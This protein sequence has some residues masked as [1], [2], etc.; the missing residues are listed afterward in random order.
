MI[1]TD[2]TP[3]LQ[4]SVAEE[5]HM[6]KRFCNGN[7]DM[8]WIILRCKTQTCKFTVCVRLPGKRIVACSASKVTTRSSVYTKHAKLLSIVCFASKVTPC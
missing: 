6:P 1:Q 5:Y 2:T 7:D 8:V 4:R 3:L